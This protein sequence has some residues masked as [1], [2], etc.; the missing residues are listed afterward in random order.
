MKVSHV[1]CR[2]VDLGAAVAWFEEKCG[3]SPSFR[4]AQIAVF[5]F[6]AFTLILDVDSFDG[7]VTVGFDS[8]DCRAD[9]EAM[10][11]RG[12]RA[13]EPPQDRPYGARGAYLQGPGAIKI[14]IE[15]LLSPAP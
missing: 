6:D 8:A 12:A 5:P 10:V 14:E 4:N 2:V 11:A 3:L 13:L 7:A 15:Q 1:H 9:F